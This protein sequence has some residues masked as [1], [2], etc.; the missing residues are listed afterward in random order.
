MKLSAGVIV[1]LLIACWLYSLDFGLDKLQAR[2]STTESRIALGVA[3]LLII[4][5]LTFI[6]SSFM[7]M[8][9]ESRNS[10]LRSVC[11]VIL[12]VLS[13]CFVWLVSHGYLFAGFGGYVF[14]LVSLVLVCG[15]AFGTYYVWVHNDKFNL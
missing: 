15:A 3:G 7:D 13:F 1:V 4:L 5:V 2:F 12:C 9:K 6:M 14:F 11:L 10:F 8:V